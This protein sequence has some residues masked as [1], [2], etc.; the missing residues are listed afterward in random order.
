MSQNDALLQTSSGVK[1]NHQVWKRGLGLGEGC[2][3]QRQVSNSPLWRDATF[4][5][6]LV[7]TVQ[8][9]ESTMAGSWAIDLPTK[10]R[11]FLDSISQLLQLVAVISII[12][13]SGI[14]IQ[15]KLLLS[16]TKH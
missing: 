16:R 3:H 14:C 5:F 8:Q 1:G 7:T 2:L 13:L 15:D 11:I 6:C 4:K 12:S 10:C 9:G